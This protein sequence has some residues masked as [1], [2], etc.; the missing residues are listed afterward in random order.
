MMHLCVVIFNRQ[1]SQAAVNTV[2]ALVL[3]HNVLALGR[4]GLALAL[5]LALAGLQ[6][7]AQ[8]PMYQEGNMPHVS[9]RQQLQGRKALA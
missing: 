5:Q 7:P 6:V 2:A 8:M 3:F 9:A 1:H 4:W